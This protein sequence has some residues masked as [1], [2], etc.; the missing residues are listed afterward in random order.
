MTIPT[1]VLF[2]GAGF[3]TRMAP[4]SDHTPKPLIEVNGKPLL[5]HAM[6]LAPDL[7]AVVN[8][9]YLADQM[10][11]AI[12]SRA[13][14][15]D[16]TDDILETGGGL[17]KA[18]PILGDGPVF[19]MNTDA[20]WRGPNPFDVLA[21]AWQDHMDGLLLL[22]AK[23]NARGYAGGGDFVMDDTNRIA[24]GPGAIYSGCQIIR[25]DLLSEVTEARFSMWELWNRMLA[26]QTLFGVNYPGLWCD[27]G[28]PESIPVAEE[29]LRQDV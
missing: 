11:A 1:H 7:Q 22:I 6:D 12:G 10:V 8:V 24:R 3:G 2:F 27:V 25:T 5:F 21:D 17:K 16:E 29:M 15:S 13:I 14:I 18:L 19:T 28:R 9:H 20:V 26:R 4:L 23:P